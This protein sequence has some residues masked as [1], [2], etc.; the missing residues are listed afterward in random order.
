MRGIV[1]KNTFAKERHFPD[2]L[3]YAIVSVS[4]SYRSQE[5]SLRI[6]Y[7]LSSLQEINTSNEPDYRFFAKLEGF[8]CG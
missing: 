2:Y 5:I 4:V 7:T 1:V 8:L 3:I 6:P